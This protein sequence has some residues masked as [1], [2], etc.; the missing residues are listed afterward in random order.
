MSKTTDPRA[1]FAAIE[2]DELRAELEELAVRGQHVRQD[3]GR[4]RPTRKQAEEAIDAGQARAA[5]LLASHANDAVNGLTAAPHA[6]GFR[7]LQLAATLHI[8]A[9]DNFAAALKEHYAAKRPS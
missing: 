3:L 1:D 9:S 4:S 5:Q 8:V 7:P 6:I 2:D